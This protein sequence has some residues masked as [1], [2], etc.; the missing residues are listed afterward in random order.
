MTMYIIHM[1]CNKRHYTNITKVSQSHCNPLS[2]APKQRWKGI[3][4]IYPCRPPRAIFQL[5]P[6]KCLRWEG[7]V[8]PFLAY[9]PTNL[10]SLICPLIGTPSFATT[11]LFLQRSR[12]IWVW[13][14]TLSLCIFISILSLLFYSI[15]QFPVKKCKEKDPLTCQTKIEYTLWFRKTLRPY[16]ISKRCTMR[17][18]TLQHLGTKS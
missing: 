4:Y 9:N 16:V 2:W 5:C 3:G 14:T 13:C 15:L 10:F 8:S 6:H 17:T 18:K 12:C 7:S 1:C 11:P